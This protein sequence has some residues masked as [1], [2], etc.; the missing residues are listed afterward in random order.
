MRA[1]F[2]DGRSCATAVRAALRNM[3]NWLVTVT[4]LLASAIGVAVLG[5]TTFFMLRAVGRNRRRA[6][7]KARGRN[8]TPLDSR[9]A[10]LI[11]I[12]Q[13]AACGENRQKLIRQCRSQE[14]V[15]LV[16]DRDHP[17]D[18][19]AVTVHRRDGRDIGML[20]RSISGDIAEY[21]DSGAPVTARIQAIE[22][23]ETDGGEMLSG[24]RIEV[25]PYRVGAG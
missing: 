1:V 11:G 5:A 12:N 20:P 23:Q 17:N 24:V 16:R 4:I 19:N 15:R 8:A 3:G 14:K 6:G 2:F 25:T 9:E 10:F 22:P 18:P 21:L 7:R 13:N